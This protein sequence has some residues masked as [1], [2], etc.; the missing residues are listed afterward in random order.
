MPEDTERGTRKWRIDHKLEAI[1]WKVIKYH[2]T[3]PLSSY[4]SHAIEEYPASNG[5][6]VMTY[7]L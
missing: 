3:K 1:G 7:L 6:V 5:P 4:L 2:E